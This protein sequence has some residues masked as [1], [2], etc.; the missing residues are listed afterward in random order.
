[1]GLVQGQAEEK[2]VLTK[3]VEQKLRNI[4]KVAYQTL[5]DT[6]I[7]ACTAASEGKIDDLK[8]IRSTTNVNLNDG[9][10]DNRTPLH[11]SCGAG[12]ENVVRYLVNEVG[13]NLSPV[14]RWG[15]TPLNDCMAWPNIRDFLKSRGAILG[16]PQPPYVAL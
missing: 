8:K 14:D 5:I 11:L 15:A 1:V 4:K 16:K 12:H 3:N 10:Y 7:A 13:V 6:V 2:I 9:D